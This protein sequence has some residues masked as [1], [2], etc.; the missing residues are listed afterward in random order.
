MVNDRLDEF[1]RF[2]RSAL[3][4]PARLLFPP[5]CPGCRRLV[6]EPGTVCGCCWPSLRFIDK[7]WC[8][9]LGTPFTHDMGDGAV[10][11]EAIA[12]PPPFRRARSAVV[13]DG[14][15]RELVHGLKFRDRTDIAP[16]IAQWMARAGAELI[17]D[18][19]AIVPVPLHARRLFWRQFNQ[20]AE[21]ARA[22]SR[23]SGKPLLTDAV[24]R[25][26]PTRQQV[27]LG[28]RAR[29]DNVRG[30]FRVP[31]TAEIDV[32]GRTL[33]VIDDVYTTGTTVAAVAKTLVRAG[34]AHV[35]VLTFARVLPGD[36]QPDQLQTI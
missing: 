29:E 14:I 6:S 8:E 9:V 7:P 28:A 31:P 11:P 13:Y 34:A 17:A 26:R 30:A 32:K 36:F 35:D 21:L 16:W 12:S 10:S 22:L 18:A 24:L 19:D 27:G 33:L 5:V 1:K 15:A 20:A 2:G 4:W 23:R 3:A 25:V